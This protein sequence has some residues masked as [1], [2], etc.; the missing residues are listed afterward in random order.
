[1]VSTAF[2]SIM[3]LLAVAPYDLGSIATTF[4]PWA[5]PWIFICGAALTALSRLISAKKKPDE[6][7]VAEP[8]E[9][10]MNFY[11]INFSRSFREQPV[12]SAHGE[13]KTEEA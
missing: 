1:M 13:T 8:A 11:T 12:T 5:K 9:A 7:P 10:A 6:T 3:T 4:P 2:F